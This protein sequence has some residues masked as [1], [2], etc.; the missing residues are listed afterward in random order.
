M[1]SPS[2]TGSN[3]GKGPKRR[4]R[5]AKADPVAMPSSPETGIVAAGDAGRGG[6]GGRDA[7]GRFASGNRFA[8][9]N[10]QAARVGRLRSAMIESV[11]IKDMGEVV[12]TVIERAKAGDMAAAKLLLDRV[13]GP[14]V[15]IDVLARIE[16]LEAAMDETPTEIG[17]KPWALTSA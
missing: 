15:A 17:V 11:T 1:P 12:A 9:G 16:A 3:G 10:P 7:R 13:L 4:P 6:S 5:G 8:I 14:V 2:P